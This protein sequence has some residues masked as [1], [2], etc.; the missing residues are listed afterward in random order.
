M[1]LTP[2]PHRHRSTVPR[3]VARLLAAAVALG[4]VL[5]MLPTALGLEH[6]VSAGSLE[7]GAT[8]RSQDLRRGDLITFVPS[9]LTRPVT[10]RIVS[11]TSG[12]AVTRSEDRRTDDP[13]GLDLGRTAVS[14]VV[15]RVPL[16]GHVLTP[17]R[18]PVVVGMGVVL[19]VLVLGDLLRS[20]TRYR[21]V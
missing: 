6:R 13:G 17:G 3:R 7:L 5:L 15:L 14:R 2:T 12:V 21:R 1:E 8:A 16:V 11:I 9:G 10:R 18:V 19:V 4:V 20:R